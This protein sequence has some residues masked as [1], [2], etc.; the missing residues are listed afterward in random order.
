AS[1]TSYLTT[2]HLGSTRVVTDQNGAVESR[3][4]YL[5][6][7]EEIQAMPD[8]QATGRSSVAGYGASDDTTQRFTSKERDT[9]S[10]LDYFGARYYSSSQ[11]RFSS[12]DP[13]AV[14]KENFVNP[15]RWNLYVYVNNNPL[16]SRDPNGGDGDGK[17]GDKVISVF[18][19]LKADQRKYDCRSKHREE[20]PGLTSRLEPDRTRG[21]PR[22]VQARSVRG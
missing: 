5:P 2:D 8:L 7:G 22:G 13:N 3:H 14:T 16:A 1:K 15:Q 21:R 17:G 19:T 20:S 4:D 9:E 11:G 10:G 18:L 6:F 12:C